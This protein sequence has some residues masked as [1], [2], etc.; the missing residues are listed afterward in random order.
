MNTK[1]LSER[2]WN[3][4][5]TSP[6]QPR[7]AIGACSRAALAVLER[8]LRE[9]YQ[10]SRPAHTLHRSVAQRSFDVVATEGKASMRGR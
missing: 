8:P 2:S 5:G 9:S 7:R 6:R 1:P 4:L 3:A 10:P